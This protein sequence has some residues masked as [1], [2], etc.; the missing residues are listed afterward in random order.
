M[1]STFKQYRRRRPRASLR[2]NIGIAVLVIA[3]AVL[4]LGAAAAPIAPGPRTPS[5]EAGNP[6]AVGVA[7]PTIRLR[8]QPIDVSFG[9]NTWPLADLDYYLDKYIPKHVREQFI[10]DIPGGSFR[11]A[12]QGAMGVQLG[13]GSISASVGVRGLATG[14]VAQDIMRVVLLGNELGATYTLDGTGFGTALF[15][16]AS[17]GLSV[18]IGSKLRVGARYHKLVGLAYAH[19][20]GEGR[21]V[22][23]NNPMDADGELSLEYAYAY[24]DD[25]SGGLK[26]AG[27]GSA[28]DVGAAWQV[29][30]NVSVGVAVLDIGQVEWDSMTSRSCE[31]STDGVD[32]DDEFE[33]LVDCSD[34]MTAPRVWKLPQRYEASVGWQATPKIHV[35]AAYTLTVHP[36]DGGFFMTGKTGSAL[37]AA[38]TWDLFRFLQLNATG[39][40]AGSDGIA[41]S[42]GAAF[43]LGPLQTR[44]RVSNVQ[45]LFGQ[46]TGKSMGFGLDFG[47]VF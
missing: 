47:I 34:E 37:R 45:A 36:A 7:E 32:P 40:M 21:V 31:L 41:L 11:L 29:S 39:T 44:A 18:P 9:N 33:D 16:D 14:G 25:S 28:F 13:I 20:S 3:V 43:R 8:F 27:D 38:V 12:G 5:D 4:S 26:G 6:A 2:L 35:G 17:V 1:K 19:V 22:I 30:P 23:P 46:G 10:A 42:T 15:G 24:V